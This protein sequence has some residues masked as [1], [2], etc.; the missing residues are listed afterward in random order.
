[1]KCS[2]KVGQ[3]GDLAQMLRLVK[4][5]AVYGDQHR[6]GYGQCHG[7]AKGVKH[8]VVQTARQFNRAAIGYGGR[9]PSAAR[10]RAPNGNKSRITSR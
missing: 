8:M 9:I 2:C 7:M 10:D 6:V 3:P 1:M 5:A 4:I